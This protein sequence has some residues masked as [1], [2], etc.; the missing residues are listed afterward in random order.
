VHHYS[1]STPIMLV[2]L[3]SDLRNANSVTT[4]E[5][6]Q[7]TQALA[8]VYSKKVISYVECSALNDSGVQGVIESA[9]RLALASSI[10]KR[11]RSD[12]CSVM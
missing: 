8:L 11:R 9:A 7:V 5:V 12:K 6:L 4:A 3:K 2:G 1:G 10:N